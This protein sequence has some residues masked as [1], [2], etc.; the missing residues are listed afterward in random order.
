METKEDFREGGG[1]GVGLG[2]SLGGPADPSCLGSG[3]AMVSS[4]RAVSG[5]SGRCADVEAWLFCRR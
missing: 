1:V 5:H 3:R 2:W 4:H